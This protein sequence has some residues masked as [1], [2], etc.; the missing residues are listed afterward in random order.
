M[1]VYS[2]VQI[3]FA[4]PYKECISVVGMRQSG[5]TNLVAWLLSQCR[6]LNVVVFDTLG[7]ISKA[8]AGWRPANLEIIVPKWNC[9]LTAK[10]IDPMLL[11]Q[12]TAACQYVWNRGNCIFV[13]DE[14][15]LFCAKKKTL[16][17][18]LFLLINQG[19][20]RNIALWF[21]SQRAAQV[22][23][24]LLAACDHHF[25]FKLWLPQDLDWMCGVLPR[26]VIYGV[27]DKNGTVKK[28][29]AKHLERWHFMYLKVGE[30]AQ[31]CK[32]VKKMY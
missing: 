9:D 27:E 17:N 8:F 14:I 30:Q 15:H 11:S 16:P 32:P 2:T 22:H 18:H 23:N 7:V 19:G 4:N 20:N 6:D 12:F 28:Q 5:K 1:T 13:I 3:R 21:T 25:I 26:E 29:G 31:F 24:D 10:E